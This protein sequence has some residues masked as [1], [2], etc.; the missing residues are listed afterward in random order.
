MSNI[1]I[2]E[3]ENIVAWDIREALE[4]LGHN[5]LADVASGQEAIKI[6]TRNQPDLILM[7]IRLE[8]EMD[9]ITAADN[10]YSCLQI[11][12]VYLTA[13]A[14]D[15][16]L[17][18]ATK[19]KPFGYLIKPFEKQE[20]HTTIQVALKRHEFETA[21]NAEKK[22]F[23]TVL[24]SIGEGIIVTDRL[25]CVMLMN[26]LA[27]GITG[28][29]QQGNLGEHLNRILHLISEEDRE[30]IDNPAL[31]AMSLGQIICNQ[32]R[33]LLR[34]QD[35]SQ[36]LVEYT[37]APIKNDK[38]QI[39]GSIIILRD[40]SELQG[41]WQ[42]LIERNQMLENFQWSLVSQLAQSETQY[43]QASNCIELLNQIFNKLPNTTSEAEIL[44]LVI[45]V[46]GCQFDADY[47]WVALYNEANTK[48]TIVSEYSKIETQQ[49][50]LMNM[51]IEMQLSP[52][53]YGHLQNLG[54]WLYPSK[55]NIPP[56]Y[57]TLLTQQNELLVI[58][59]ACYHSGKKNQRGIGEIG[60]FTT[61]QPPIKDPVVKLITE[62]ASYAVELFR[63]T[64]LLST[65]EVENAQLELKR[66]RDDFISSVSEELLNPLVNM[67]IAA[68]MLRHLVS[69]LSVGTLQNQN[70]I[71][72]SGQLLKR[73]LE[74][75]L[76]IWQEEW[77]EEVDLINT[78][79]DL[80]GI[81]RQKESFP[82]SKVDLQQWFSK[83]LQRFS[84]KIIQQGGSLHYQ[85]SPR[86]PIAMLHLPTLEQIVTELINNACKHTPPNQPMIFTASLS[87][88]NRLEICL[89][90]TGLNIP[91]DELENIFQPFYRIPRP[92]HWH[93]SGMG[94]GLALVK[95]LVVRLGG[96]I[97]AKS[98]DGVTIFTVTCDLFN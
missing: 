63:Q 82:R 6:A 11:P 26:P 67:E 62:I 9:G 39:V 94:L 65:K 24:K 43:Y 57:Q 55:E 20:L 77:Q 48:A 87:R 35:G 10:I 15:D 71:F 70:Q 86:L 51:E 19:T 88:E 36:K 61:N 72:P 60:I 93:H 23:S 89:T 41:A 69:S 40:N 80:Q 84:Q 34:S 21:A 13:H 95:K 56:P 52:R 25:G 18:R 42:E 96:E 54:N 97:T 46:I 58:P 31:R 32:E 66:L 78:L 68:E 33:C 75:Y 45:N 14:D 30:T 53:F 27:E 90:N 29:Q 1:L 79:L 83:I 85:I 12:I 28:W 17:E 5:V 50:I 64:H 2:V 22:W 38:R 4:Q 59:I 44:D 8:G 92:Y 16:T 91:P 73:K 3:D 49:R 98:H 47:C 81:D 76:Q 74:E 37:A 7:D